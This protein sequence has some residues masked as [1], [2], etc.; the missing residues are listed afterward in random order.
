MDRI[1]RSSGLYRAK[2]ERADYRESTISRAVNGT[3][4]FYMPPEISSADEDFTALDDD[5]VSNEEPIP[6]DEMTVPAFPVDALPED[7]RNYVLAVAESTQT[8]VDV[9][10]CASLSVLSIGMQGKYAVRP[11]PD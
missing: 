8:P 4:D 11:K 6:L 7:I 2:W 1:Y 9:A 10:A 3:A 5:Q